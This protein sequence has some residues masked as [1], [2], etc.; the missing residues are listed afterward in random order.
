ME[1]FDT[2]ARWMWP[3]LIV[4]TVGGS[5]YVALARSGELLATHAELVTPMLALPLILAYGLTNVLSWRK[6]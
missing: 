4:L 2:L 6:R 1:R 5:L 3:C